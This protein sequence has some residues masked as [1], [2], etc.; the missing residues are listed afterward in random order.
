M[1][2]LWNHDRRNAAEDEEY[3]EADDEQRCSPSAIRRQLVEVVSSAVL[4]NDEEGTL[5]GKCFACWGRWN[6]T[7]QFFDFSVYWPFLFILHLQ[8]IPVLRL[9]AAAVSLLKNSTQ[10]VYHFLKQWTPQALLADPRPVTPVRDQTML[11]H[12]LR[13]DFSGKKKPQN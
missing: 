10:R 7:P 1:Q 5:F 11:D 12:S 4:R 8:M 2:T 3:F 9:Q 13:Y 6:R